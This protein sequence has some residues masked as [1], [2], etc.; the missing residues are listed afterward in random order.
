VFRFNTF[1]P[2]SYYQH[3]LANGNTYNEI[4]NLRILNGINSIEV[5]MTPMYKL[6]ID[7]GLSPF[8]IFQI[9]SIVVWCLYEYYYYAGLIFVITIVSAILTIVLFNLFNF[10]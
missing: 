9:F 1:K 5:P 10:F 8:N 4:D 6:I 2:F 3:D 7:E